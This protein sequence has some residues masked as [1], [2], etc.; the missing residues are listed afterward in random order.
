MNSQ[1]IIKL[2]Q[3]FIDDNNIYMVLE[4]CNMGDLYKYQMDLPGKVFTLEKATK[5]LRDVIIGLEEVHKSGSVH[6]DIKGNNILVH[7]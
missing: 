3:D 6:R 5:V 7:S 4:Y 1:Y 2:Y